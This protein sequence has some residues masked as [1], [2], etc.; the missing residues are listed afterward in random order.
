M[1]AVSTP[2]F[3]GEPAEEGAAVAEAGAAC[4]RQLTARTTPRQRNSPRSRKVCTPFER[5][6]PDP[7]VAAPPDSL[8]RRRGNK[9]SEKSGVDG[10]GK[11]AGA[12]EIQAHRVR[13]FTRRGRP[14]QSEATRR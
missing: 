7:L 13:R 8:Q 9:T 6:G 12:G 5:Q 11:R 14:A 4:S 2:G 3:S 1:L 10:P